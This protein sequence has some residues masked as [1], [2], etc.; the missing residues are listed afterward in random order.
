MSDTVRHSILVAQGFP[1]II[2]A[3]SQVLILGTMPSVE[4][5]R[6]QEYYGHP[7]NQFWRILA[8]IFHMPLAETYSERVT[9]LLQKQLAVWDVLQYCERQGSLDQAIRKAVPNDFRGLFK[10]YGNLGVVVFNGRKARDLFEHAVLKQQGLDESEL[11]RLLMP[12]TSPTATLP[13]S[14]KVE[15][16]RQICAFLPL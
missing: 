13:I 9:F 5:L 16:W 10:T 3:T 7:R 15:R 2:D 14:T 1:P 12:S 4:S 6:R 8:N 11:P